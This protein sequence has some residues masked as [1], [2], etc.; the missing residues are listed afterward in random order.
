MANE[1]PYRT[2][3][4]DWLQDCYLYEDQL[5]AEFEEDGTIKT[6]AFEPPDRWRRIELDPW[7]FE[8]ADIA[9]VPYPRSIPQFVFEDYVELRKRQYSQEQKANKEGTSGVD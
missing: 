9:G 6:F 5:I 4:P 8:W 2:Q 7:L 3:I 1:E